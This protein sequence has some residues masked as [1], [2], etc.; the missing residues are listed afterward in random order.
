ME[1]ANRKGFSYKLEPEIIEEYRR[2]PIERRLKW[3]LAG[4]RLRRKLPAKI[5]ELQD[6]YR[7]GKI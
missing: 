5:I 6:A 7:E 1:K 3:L 2:W 4:N